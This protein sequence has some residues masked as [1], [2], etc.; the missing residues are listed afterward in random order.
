MAKPT[1]LYFTD[2]EA[3]R[4]LIASDPM[5]LLIG[6]ALDQQV[7]VQKAFDGPRAIKER[8]GSLDP[9]VLA[10]T[11]L[12]PVFRE[13][14]AIHRYPGNMAKRIS[15]LAAAVVE[16]YDGDAAQVW[17]SAKTPEELLKNVLALPGFGDLSGH[18]LI[19]ALALRFDVKNAKPLVPD[20]PMLGEV[21]SMAELEA[22]QTAKKQNKKEWY[23]IYKKGAK[24]S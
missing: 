20:H 2:D 16:D 6:F 14:P 17:K 23:A 22:Y 12:E 21:T 24:R 10:S 13:K 7:T 1:Q 8:V 15:A 18:A 4:K 19:G 3:A 9:A 5:A 11:D